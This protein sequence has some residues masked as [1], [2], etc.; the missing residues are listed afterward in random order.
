MQPEGRRETHRHWA[1][2]ASS[3]TRVHGA[4]A[5]E[6]VHQQKTA[7]AEGVF[8]NGPSTTSANSSDQMRRPS[9]QESGRAT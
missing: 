9:V 1:R 4:D 5:R 3:T 6:E 7:E 8:H 2:K